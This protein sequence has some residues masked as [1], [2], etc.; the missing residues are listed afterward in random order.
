LDS[1]QCWSPGLAGCNRQLFEQALARDPKFALV[2]ALL[3]WTYLRE[4]ILQWSQDPQT[5]EQASAL[6]Q[7]A[8]TLDDSLPGAHMILGVVCQWKRQP[9]QAIVEGERATTL[10][11]NYADAYVWLAECLSGDL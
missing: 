2:Y 4:W 10:D 11:P 9:E 7:K 1:A 3:G 5:L 8:I 6:A